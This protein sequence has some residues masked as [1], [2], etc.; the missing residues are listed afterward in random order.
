MSSDHY[1][2]DLTFR[3]PKMMVNWDFYQCIL[4]NNPFKPD[5]RYSNSE[6]IWLG[7]PYTT[8]TDTF[9]VC[10]VTSHTRHSVKYVMFTTR[11][12]KDSL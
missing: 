6:A 2:G 10:I 3:S 12:A 7:D 11:T 4:L 1:P 5:K 8:S 9:L